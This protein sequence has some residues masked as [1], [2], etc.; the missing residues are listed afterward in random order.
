M[1]LI[2][3]VNMYTLMFICEFSLQAEL[4]YPLHKILTMSF[5][6]GTH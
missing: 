2:C 5:S 6:R 1:R 4:K 3:E